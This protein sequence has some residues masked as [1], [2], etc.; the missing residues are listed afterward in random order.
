MNR[1]HLIT[2]AVLASFGAVGGS[3]QAAGNDDP[4]YVTTPVAITSELTRDEVRAELV[5]ARAEGRMELAGEIT[6]PDSVLIAME[7]HTQILALVAQQRA[8]LL[9]LIESNESTPRAS[10]RDMSDLSAAGSSS[11]AN[12]MGGGFDDSG[13]TAIPGSIDTQQAVSP[14]TLDDLSMTPSNPAQTETLPSNPDVAPEWSQASDRQRGIEY[15]PVYQPV[16]M[17]LE[18]DEDGEPAFVET[19]DM[20]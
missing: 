19:M 16:L 6:T 8:E 10:S 7:N 15:G 12:A 11:G 9:A 14:S 4:A 13:V 20:N 17:V 3:A 18:L 5:A 2:L 1:K